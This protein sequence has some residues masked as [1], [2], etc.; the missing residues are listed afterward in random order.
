LEVVSQ[1]GVGCKY[2]LKLPISQVEID[3]YKKKPIRIEGKTNSEYNLK[4]EEGDGAMIQQ[5]FIKQV[6][7]T[8]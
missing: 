5:Q 4:T 8:T 6:A 2:I 1:Q 3:E 7:E